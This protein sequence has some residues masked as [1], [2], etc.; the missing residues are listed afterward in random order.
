MKTFETHVQAGRIVFLPENGEVRAVYRGLRLFMRE[1]R[2]SGR[3]IIFT[4]ALKNE[5][6]TVDYV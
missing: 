4:K 6:V 1:W 5:N 3:N 2:Q